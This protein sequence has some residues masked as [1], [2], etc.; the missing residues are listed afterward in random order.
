MALKPL[1]SS[2]LEGSLVDEKMVSC[3]DPEGVQP[4]VVGIV[5]KKVPWLLTRENSF[6]LKILE[7]ELVSAD[8]SYVT[9]NADGTT[10]RSPN[11]TQV[12]VSKNSDLYW[13]LRGGGGSTW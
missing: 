11:G 9:A 7:V 6:C 10:V 2:Q 13:A 12:S 3:S 8:G 4:S 5:R 1:G